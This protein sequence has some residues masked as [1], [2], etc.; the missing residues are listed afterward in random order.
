MIIKILSTYCESAVSIDIIALTENVCIQNVWWKKIA[1][2]V[3]IICH[4]SLLT[5]SV[6]SVNS[7]NTADDVISVWSNYRQ[8]ELTQEQNQCL[9]QELWVSY[10]LS[11]KWRIK[12]VEV[13]RFCLRRSQW[14]FVSLHSYLSAWK[15]LTISQKPL[16]SPCSLTSY[17]LYSVRTHISKSKFLSAKAVTTIMSMFI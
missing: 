10:N 15:G 12:S 4:L 9:L 5:V 1:K 8:N 6:E 17:M 2:P 16:C 13:I 11:L 7:Y 3:N 14:C